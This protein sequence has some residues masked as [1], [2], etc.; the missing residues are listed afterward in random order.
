[1]NPVAFLETGVIHCA[2]N[3]ATLGQLPDECVDLVYLDPPFFSNRFYEVI[4]GDE[5][6]VR[7][8]ED[9]W[10]GGINVYLEWMEARLRHLH[11]IL[12]PTGSLY[13]HC[14]PAAGHYLKVMVD[15][16]FGMRN[17]RNEL[18]WQRAVAKGDARRK[19]PANHDTVLGYGRTA[20]TYFLPARREQ[21]EEYIARFRYDD[22]DGRGLY[23]LAPLDSPNPRPNLTYEYKGFPPPV[24]GWRVSREV[25]ERLD[26][27]GR[28]AF[29][30]KPEGRI[31]RKHYLEEQDG[32]I[33]G[34]VWTDIPP[35]QAASAERLGYPT[36]KPEA[37][38]ERIIEAGSA[39][40]SIVLDP[41]CGCG[42]TI[43]VA[44]KLQRQWIGIDISFQAV[45]IIKLRMNKLGASP[46]VLGLPTNA[47]DLRSLGPFEFQHWIIQRVMG[48]PSPRD[49]ADGGID[50]FSF[51]EQLPI[52][53]K[54]RERVGREDV[55]KFETA[56]ERTEK[57]KGYI[58]AFS[59]T[60]TAREE[61]SRARRAGGPEVVLV[62]VE[63]VVRVG[64]LIDSADRDGRPPDLSGVT[65]DLM[66]LFSALQ[67]SVRERSFYPPPPRKAKPSAAE[68]IE[69]ARRSNP[70]QL[71]IKP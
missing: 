51:F 6:E 66:G 33:V 3:L 37:L 59:F 49:V 19:F 55:D 47:G 13:L 56:I 30:A 64:A 5:A 44:E 46:K 48:T 36:Q 29:P 42:T 38:L 69:S 40:G 43:A 50:G 45:E 16:I 62:E 11:R 2:D 71:Q 54:Q 31:A 65:P 4:W 15:G 23:R 57:D 39:P 17:F 21:D 35:L 7:S 18:V 26:D 10:E 25:M 12:K 60:R 53:V 68:L 41:F 28:L 32:P 20:K 58:V 70:R 9:R 8:F 61:C 52:Q 22:H 24:K 34:D 67:E 27:E 1:M 14:D 63:D